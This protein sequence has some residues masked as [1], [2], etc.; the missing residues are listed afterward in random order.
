VNYY[1]SQTLFGRLNKNFLLPIKVPQG[2]NNLI[3]WLETYNLIKIHVNTHTHKTT[4]KYI[5]VQWQ[6]GQMRAKQ[7]LGDLLY[8]LRFFLLLLLLLL[9]HP[10]RS[11]VTYCYSTFLFHYYYYYSYY[12]YS[13]THFCPLYF[14]EMPWSNFMK[15]CRNII[16]HVKLCCI[17]LI[18]SKWLPLPW[19]QPKC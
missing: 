13:S 15:P 18:F 11:R 9:R 16:C 1:S 19:K 4:G 12:Y 5:Y 6:H 10:E 3:Q 2:A 8:L 7:S 17:G 14:S